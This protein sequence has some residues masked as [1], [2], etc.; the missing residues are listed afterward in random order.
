[1]P[2]FFKIELC[3]GVS[4]MAINTRDLHQRRQ[5]ILESL[6]MSWLFT[7][8]CVTGDVGENPDKR[9]SRVGHVRIEA[10]LS[11]P[12]LADPGTLLGFESGHDLVDVRLVAASVIIFG[13]GVLVDAGDEL[14]GIDVGCSGGG[15]ISCMFLRL[16]RGGLF[17]WGE[18]FRSIGHDTS[19]DGLRFL[20]HS[21]NEFGVVFC[22]VVLLTEIL[23]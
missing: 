19:V 21:G 5:C 17:F 22:D 10:T 1:M 23:R 18:P 20:F 7:F 14:R 15:P 4:I 12:E 13:D 16:L 2:K 9:G 6:S 8:S 11:F 3:L